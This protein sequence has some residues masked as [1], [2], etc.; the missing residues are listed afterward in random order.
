MNADHH[1][2]QASQRLAQ[3]LEP[4]DLDQTLSRITAAAVEVL[5]SVAYASI[6]VRHADGRLE[7]VAPTHDLLLGIDAAQYDL[8][9]GPCYH[10]ATDEV[11]VASPDLANDPRFPKYGPLAVAAGIA[12]QA[13]IRLF[14]TSDAHG[15]LNLY[16]EETGTFS[17]MGALGELFAHQAAMALAYARQI[18]QLQ[19][20]VQNRQLIGQAVGVTMERFSLD[21]ARAFGF[22]ARLSQDNNIKLRVVAER[23]LAE[24]GRK[25]A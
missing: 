24:T 9:E 22:L 1:M 16:S 3:V 2:L 13:G 15:A 11:H 5:P 14:D 4:G 6:T 20:A 7:T 21:E 19:E 18:T 12:S 23:L 8:G 10:A 25:D 17:D